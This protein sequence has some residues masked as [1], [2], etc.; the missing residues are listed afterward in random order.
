MYKFGNGSNLSHKRKCERRYRYS[1]DR[2]FSSGQRH[3]TRC[4]YRFWWE[5]H[6]RKRQKRSVVSFL[7]C[8]LHYPRENGSQWQ[9]A[10]YHFG[11]GYSNPRWSGA[12][13]VWH[14][15]GKG[16]NGFCISSGC[17]NYRRPQTGR[18][19]YC[20]A[21]YYLRGECKQGFRFSWG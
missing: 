14:S 17:E 4:L 8:R 19:R 21:R 16:R 9:S 7:L 12:Y 5:F 6:L 18:C 1:Y 20:T 11:R 2:G 3:F 15:K 10:K 13:W